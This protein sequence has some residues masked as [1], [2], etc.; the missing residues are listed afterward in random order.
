MKITIEKIFFKIIMPECFTKCHTQY[1]TVCTECLCIVFKDVPECF[2]TEWLSRALWYNTLQV[3]LYTE[4]HY[5]ILVHEDI[6]VPS[7]FI[8]SVC[9]PHSV[10]CKVHDCLVCTECELS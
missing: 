6:N 5:V 3:F 8:L 1:N 7:L 4:C 2:C 10:Q 9:L